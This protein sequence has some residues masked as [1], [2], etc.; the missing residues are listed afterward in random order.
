MDLAPLLQEYG[1]MV[2]LVLFFTWQG[3][4]REQRLVQRIDTIEREYNDTLKNLVAR[5]NE[6]IAANTE[7]MHQLRLLIRSQNGG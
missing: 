7:I 5:S 2:T 6:V 4:R 1:I 3:W